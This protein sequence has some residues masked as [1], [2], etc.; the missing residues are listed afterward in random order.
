MFQF[1]KPLLGLAAAAVLATAAPALAQDEGPIKVG[2]LHS[3]SGTMAI[4]ETT[5]SDVMLMLI[6]QRL[7]SHFKCDTELRGECLDWCFEA[8]TLSRRSIEIPD[9]AVDVFVAVAA[10]ACPSRQVSP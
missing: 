1:R 8:E 3:L 7:D 6:E 4:S 10:E 2:I 9:D 5:L